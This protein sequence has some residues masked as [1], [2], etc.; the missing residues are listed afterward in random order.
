MNIDGIG[1]KINSNTY[2]SAKSKA[3]DDDFEKRLQSVFDYKDDKELK[4]VCKEFE[5]ILLNMMYKE[6]KA[7]VPKSNLIPDDAGQDIFESMQDEN[8]MNEA[9]KTNRLG[10]ADMLYKQLSNKLKSTY[11]PVNGG[12]QGVV[13]SSTDI[14]NNEIK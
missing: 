10:L 1:G 9:A 5:G 6:M 11:K 14:Q 3:A 4:N 7:T 8:L 12:D 2:N 13:K